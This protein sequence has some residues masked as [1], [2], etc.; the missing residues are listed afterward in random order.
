[1]STI[2]LTKKAIRL[3]ELCEAAG[4]KTVED[5]VRASMLDS[6][7]PAICMGCGATTEMEGDQRRGYCESCGKNRVVS[8]LVLADVI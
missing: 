6:G 4:F 3:F 7:C 5:L 8:G 2:A 1:M